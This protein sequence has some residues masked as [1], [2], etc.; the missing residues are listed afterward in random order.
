MVEPSLQ[1]F[2]DGDDVALKKVYVEY[3]G[4]FINYARKF[5]LDEE[6]ILDIYQDAIIALHENFA[7]GKIKEMDSSIKT[8][9]FSIG[10]YKIYSYLRKHNKMR[11]LDD[12]HIPDTETKGFDFEL[13]ENPLTEKQAILKKALEK[14]GGKCKLI[15]ELFYFRGLTIDEI[16]VSENYENNNTVKSQKSRCLKT[17]KEMIL[18][19]QP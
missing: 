12:Q 14:M 7:S 8:Y 4:P 6:A 3:R 2:K 16:R 11:V 18:K 19:P 13:D 17:L 9:L 5:Q 15:L 10:K 1:S